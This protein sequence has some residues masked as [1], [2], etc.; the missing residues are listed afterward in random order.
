VLTRATWFAPLVGAALLAAGCGGSDESATTK[1]FDNVCS[2]VTTWQDSI[3][4]AGQSLKN[5][6]SKAGLESA[7]TDAKD[8]TST[9][10][11]DLESAGKPDT[12]SGEQAKEALDTLGTQLDDG[13]T[14]MQDSVGGVSTVNE[15]LTAVSAVSGTLATMSTQIKSTVD[16]LRTLDAKGELQTA[17][18][19][20][21][22]CA[23]LK[24]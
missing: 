17:F 23:P 18:N 13:V 15:A 3:S 11:D 14:K 16:N 21:D 10:S 19:E 2:A 9:L 8:A 20:A 6:P 5:N 1:W 12:D 24:S 4:G 22:S 7:F